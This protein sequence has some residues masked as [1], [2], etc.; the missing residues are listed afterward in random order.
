MGTGLLNVVNQFYW[1]QKAASM[2][3]QNRKGA[4][5]QGRIP[6]QDGRVQSWNSIVQDKR[7]EAQSWNSIVQDKRNGVQ[8]SDNRVD[9]GSTLFAKTMKSA[10]STQKTEETGAT[11]ADRYKNYLQSKYGC[12]LM[13]RDMGKDQKSFDAL[14]AG[15]AGCS[16]VVIAPDILEKMANDPE[17]AAYYEGKIQDY[18]DSVPRYQAELSAMGHEIHSS[19]MVIHSDGTVT[20]YICG[21][22]KPEV[23]ARIEARVKAEQEEKAN[24]RKM[25]MELG[26]EAAEERRQITEYYSE[27][28]AAVRALQNRVFS[29]DRLADT[30][31][32]PELF[33]VVWAAYNRVNMESV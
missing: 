4:G 18:F 15:T 17:K 27:R 10:E 11:N 25:Y 6:G 5:G 12:V 19:G 26:K 7:N 14:G 33:R 22:L 24:R 8:S 32:S 20:H 3:G 23:R 1:E 13:V 28:Q 2:K 29:T 21:D 31:V 9:F 16:N 30:A